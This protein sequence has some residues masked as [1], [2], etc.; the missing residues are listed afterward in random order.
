MTS[1]TQTQTQTHQNIINNLIHEKNILK[2]EINKELGAD[3]K[4]HRYEDIV[5]DDH[6]QQQR[7]NNGIIRINVDSNNNRSIPERKSGTF[8]VEQ[9]RA[10]TLV[11]D[12][13]NNDKFAR[14]PVNIDGQMHVHKNEVEINEQQQRINYFNLAQ[15][16]VEELNRQLELIE[17]EK[18]NQV[19]LFKCI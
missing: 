17:K 10:Q 3:L 12:D 18:L 15:K 5:D 8:E 4:I 7:R 1:S 19:E 16:S 9:Q 6:Y 13:A 14:R 11:I 2:V